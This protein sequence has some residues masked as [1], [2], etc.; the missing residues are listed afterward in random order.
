MAKSGVDFA[1]SVL[2]NAHISIVFLGH[3]SFLPACSAILNFKNGH[4]SSLGFSI[5]VGDLCLLYLWLPMIRYGYCVIDTS[6]SLFKA[7]ISKWRTHVKIKHQENVNLVLQIKTKRKQKVPKRTIGIIE[8]C[9]LENT[10][11]TK[12]IKTGAQSVNE[13]YFKKYYLNI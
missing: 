4:G 8:L 11:A 7:R 12:L 3:L 10:R 9:L 5:G 13:A 6:S 2:E 1:Q